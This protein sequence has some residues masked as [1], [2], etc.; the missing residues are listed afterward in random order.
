GWR[1]AGAEA[2]DLAGEADALAALG[3]AQLAERLRAVATA[4]SVAEALAAI[5]LA[6][7]ACRLLRARL[8]AAAAPPDRGVDLWRIEGPPPADDW[9][10]W[11]RYS[12]RGHLQWLARYP[13]GATG[14][15]ERCRLA[16]AEWSAPTEAREAALSQLRSTIAAGKLEDNQPVVGSGGGLRLKLL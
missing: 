3:L 11:L 1:D 12:L 2:A 10:P 8:P 13:L 15:V 7:A 16:T 4:P 14:K 9:R 6:A 5:V